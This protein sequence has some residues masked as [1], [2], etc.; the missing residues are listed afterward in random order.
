MAP[1]TKTF[2]NGPWRGA[3]YISE[4]TEAS[5][6]RLYI[7]LNGYIPDAVNRSGY[8][9][10]PGFN[11]PTN[12]ATTGNAPQGVYAHQALDGTNYNFIFAN[13]KVWRWS[14]NLTSA[15]VDVTPTNVVIGTGK[16]VYATSL[17]DTMIVNDGVNKMWVASN[18]SA[19][20]ITATVIETDTPSNVL[21]IGSNDVRLANAAF[22]GT[23]SGTQATFAANAVGTA[24]GA[25]GQIA[26]NTW[27]IIL[28]EATTSSAL[29]FTAA[30]NAGA[31]YATEAL[32]IAALPARTAARRYV[33]Y[34]T[35]RADAGAVWIAG[36]DAFATGTTGNQAQTTNYYAGEGRAYSVFGQPVIY[37]GALFVIYQQIAA[38]YARTTIGWS[39][40][41]LPAEGYQQTDYDNQWTLTQTASDPLYVLAATNDALY[42]SRQLSWGAIAGAPGVNFQGTATHDVVSGNVGCVSPATVARFLNYVYFCDVQGR[43]WR[44]AV[45]GTP[46][47]L[48]LQA[49]EIYEDNAV[50]INAA[51]TLGN[52][53]A[54]VEPNL[55]LYLTFTAPTVVAETVARIAQVF[56][57]TTGT[58]V[59]QW[60]VGADAAPQD[61]GGVVRNANGQTCLAILEGPTV[62]HTTTLLVWRLTLTSEAIWG[63][64][65]STLSWAAETGWN[66]FGS[67]E[68]WDA[69]KF[70][71]LGEMGDGSGSS[72]SV[73]LTANTTMG[74]NTVGSVT[75]TAPS[76]A[77]AGRSVRW[78]W[79]GNGQTMGR[80][81]R[82]RVSTTV[83]NASGQFKCYRIEALAVESMAGIEDR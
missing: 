66:G 82:L 33:G 39:E 73:T 13:G 24:V 61:I 6:D 43:P 9:S 59:G 42:Y 68:S 54:T 60:T 2:T 76:G 48:W 32:A 83:P 14:T 46:E 23:W 30:F 12:V 25:L 20:P 21:S 38:A 64:G 17:A 51:V 18:L 72:Q 74:A 63:D 80:G 65:G 15:P 7:G 69:T 29:A 47:P 27:G 81:F 75:A 79:M 70:A 4:P 16:F 78:V 22:T 36:T 35:V 50:Q 41:N 11:Q 52:A 1:K 5:A 44:F 71:M 8:Y 45:G 10:R 77:V 62:A 56:D 58:Y 49:R 57:L 3:R 19:T 26:A 37:T 31:G 53:W 55:G 67:F 28:V 34:V 40:P